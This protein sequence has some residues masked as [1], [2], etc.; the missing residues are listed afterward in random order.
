MT[1]R[2]GL[3]VTSGVVRV[4]STDV[5]NSSDKLTLVN[6]SGNCSLTIDSTPTAESSV[7]FADGTSGNDAYRGYLQYS[8]T[9]DALLIGTSGSERLRIDSSGR[10]GLGT[11]SPAEKLHVNATGTTAGDG[12]IV[13]RFYDAAQSK[14][15]FLG[16][17]SNEVGGT[18]YGANLLTFQTYNGSSWGERMRIDGSGRLL[19]GTNTATKNADRSSGSTFALAGVT[20]YPSVV[21]TGYSNGNNDQG[22]LIDLQKSRGA[23]DGAMTVVA[24]ADRLGTLNFLGSDGTNFLRAAD[25]SAFV[26]GTPGSNDMP[27]RLVFST[28]ADGA[29]SPTERMR[30]T[31]EGE[32]YITGGAANGS[33]HFWEGASVS[34]NSDTG[35]LG[36]GKNG[37]AL[38]YTN[39]SSPA[40]NVF[41]I[42]SSGATPLVF[43]TTNVERMRIDSSGR[44]GLGTNNPGSFSSGGGDQLVVSNSG[45]DC[46][47]TIH[48]GT[49][50]L[51]RLLFADGTGTDSYR[52]FIAYE[53]SSDSFRIGTS[54]TDDIRIDSSGNMGLGTAS[55]TQK[56]DVRGNVYIGSK[57]GIDT[58]NPQW[59]LVISDSGTSGIE[60]SGRAAGPFIQSYNRSASVYTSL[61]LYAAHLDFY[62]GSGGS[63]FQ[64]LKITSSGTLN[65]GG[66][67]SQTT[68]LLHLTGGNGGNGQADILTL[69]HPNTTSTGDGPALSLNGYYSGNPWSFAKIT[70]VNSG[71]GFGADLQIHVHPANGTQGASLVKA[72]SIVG[73]GGS[74]ANVTITDGNLKIG[75]SGHGI[76][77]SV[78]GDTSGVTS[79]LLDDYEEGTC[80]MYISTTGGGLSILYGN[81]TAYYV[82]VGQMVT[83]SW[84]TGQMN[85]SNAGSGIAIIQ[86]F[87]YTSFN[88]SDHYAV[89]NIEHA[90]CFTTTVSGGYITP[91]TS[92]GVPIQPGAT[93]GVGLSAGSIKYLMMTATYRAN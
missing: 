34:G 61:G 14:G 76:D 49:S 57:L 29:S 74:G 93:N 67:Y 56:L 51:S 77:F 1:A 30:I 87:P 82:K 6:N 65:V 11:N 86:G 45:G 88:G 39:V 7:F 43:S 37:N 68:S 75:T 50:S 21:V 36:V 66:D 63:T 10:M 15:L 20:N 27:G 4:G 38:I 28:T 72:V 69:K 12:A 19:V 73:D 2:S 84:Y 54:S 35:R 79:E 91:N 17:D 16:Y 31:N 41:A 92:Q 55:P 46:G 26:D 25:I 60:M 13:A 53:H 44:M 18:I 90:T 81:Q 83:V 9:N 48:A 58:T 62:T 33:L 71:S 24:S 3:N 80:T 64:R 22:P 85:I 32:M 8:H 59:P 89:M 52:G 47:I 23:S 70:S 5:Y 42:G 78:T 40:R